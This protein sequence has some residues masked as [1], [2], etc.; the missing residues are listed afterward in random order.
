VAAPDRLEKLPQ[1]SI[2]C[3]TWKSKLIT[4]WIDFAF[5]CWSSFCYL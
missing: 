5:S 4:A 2:C 3:Q 1:N